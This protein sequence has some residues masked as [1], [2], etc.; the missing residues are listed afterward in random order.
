MSRFVQ[1]KLKFEKKEERETKNILKAKSKF[2]LFNTEYINT[3]SDFKPIE[4]CSEFPT[5][6]LP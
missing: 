4:Y 6:A 3:C 5:L 2:A 1:A